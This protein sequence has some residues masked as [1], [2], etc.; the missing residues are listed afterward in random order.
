MRTFDIERDYYCNGEK[1]FNMDKCT[2]NPGVTILV[3]CNGYG[4]SSLLTHISH[5][6][7]SEKIKSIKYDDVTE[8]RSIAKDAA[9]K[10]YKDVHLLATMALSSEGENIIIN[11]GKFANKIGKFCAANEDEKELWI[12]LDAID[13]GLSIDN[14]CYIKNL[15]NLIIENETKNN[16]KK[17][18]IVATANTYELARGE[19]CF[20]VHNGK[21]ITFE[22]YEHYRNFILE[23]HATK[24]KR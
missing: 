23:T 24:Q 11:L 21:Y 1:M 20:D 12:L 13:S 3:G 22:D 7:D 10:I 5:T 9:M 14:I 19:Q 18:Y 17:I 6:L 8:G 2:I 15:F 16:D 4:K